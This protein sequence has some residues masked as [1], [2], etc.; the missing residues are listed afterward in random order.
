MMAH[1]W[2]AVFLGL[3]VLTLVLFAG[4]QRWTSAKQQQMRAEAFRLWFQK[5]YLG[6]KAEG[7]ST[8]PLKGATR[9][10]KASA[11]IDREKPAS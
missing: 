3:M 2:I 5:N 11:S 4:L 9:S 1:L 10:R 7:D 6:V 8:A